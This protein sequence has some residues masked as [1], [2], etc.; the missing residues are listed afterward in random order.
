MARAT[1]YGRAVA[2]W[3]RNYPL[4]PRYR[5]DELVTLTT[6]DG[7]RLNAARLVGPADARFTVVL[8][9][10]FVNS[11]RTPRIHA[12]ARLLQSSACVIVPDLRGHGASKG[13]TTM[14][15]NETLDVDAAVRAAGAGSPVVT[16]GSSL[17]GSAA[18]LHAGQH[19][20]VAG[21]VAI[22]AA[23]WGG[24]EG[25]TGSARAARFVR[26]RAGRQVGGTTPED[27]HTSRLRVGSRRARRGR[28]RQPGLSHRGAR[29]RRPL[30]RRRPRPRALRLGTRAE[31]AVV[32]ATRGARH[33]P[34]DACV[35]RSPA[36]RAQPSSSRPF[37][38]SQP[39][40]RSV[41]G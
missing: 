23:A 15:L 30:L 12:F 28:Q 38:M 3:A 41:R 8:L 5:R 36:R 24:E 27:P 32:A 31:R 37:A 4:A 14:G 16:V 17:G 13:H 6:A 34:P 11:S 7:V 33:R 25:R 19:G 1:D 26:S 40:A 18:I 2:R 9:H 20:G 10:G 29:P 39:R 21:V 22:S 35:R